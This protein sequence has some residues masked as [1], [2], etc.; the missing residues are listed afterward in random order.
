MA[1]RNCPVEGCGSRISSEILLCRDHWN[2]VP[3]ELRGLAWSTYHDALRQLN[4]DGMV[5]TTTFLEARQAATES[6]ARSTLV[7]YFEELRA[8]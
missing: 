6:A 3:A 2:R 4:R 8:A 7:D 5:D 1:L